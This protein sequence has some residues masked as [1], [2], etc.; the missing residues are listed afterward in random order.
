MCTRLSKI[1]DVITVFNTNYLILGRNILTFL[2]E[3]EKAEEDARSEINLVRFNCYLFFSL[4]NSATPIYTRN[5][6][7]HP[8]LVLLLDGR[9]FVFLT[10]HD[11]LFLCGEN[12]RRSQ[13]WPPPS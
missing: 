6:E 10:F 5:G 11:I 2:D 8:F 9:P 12:E 4:Q 7:F 3:V 1:T 13:S